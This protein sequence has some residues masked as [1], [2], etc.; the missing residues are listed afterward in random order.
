M[1]YCREICGY[2][3][4]EAPLQHIN[5]EALPILRLSML[6]IA[7]LFLLKAEHITPGPA[8]TCRVLVENH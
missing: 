6:Q 3:G 7:L 8:L 2:E 5:G 4:G 1:N